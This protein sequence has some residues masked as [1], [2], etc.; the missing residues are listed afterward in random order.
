MTNGFI[1]INTNHTSKQPKFG[2]VFYSIYMATFYKIDN[3]KTFRTGKM[4]KKETITNLYFF[5]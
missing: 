3:H 2:V 5:R 1:S 4:V